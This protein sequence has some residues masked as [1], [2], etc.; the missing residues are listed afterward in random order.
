MVHDDELADAQQP[1][2]GPSQALG[3]VPE[4]DQ[5]AVVYVPF[6]CLRLKLMA[7]SRGIRPSW[8]T[9]HQASV[10]SKQANF[11]PFLG[12][13]FK[14]CSCLSPLNPWPILP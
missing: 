2:P 14:W 3:R 1:L 4:V 6:L 5:K 12:P 8:D 13:N 7:S 10:V 11:L 9:A